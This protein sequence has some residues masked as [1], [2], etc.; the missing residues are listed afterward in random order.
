MQT[1]TNNVPVAPMA[2]KTGYQPRFERPV[3]RMKAT[4]S[5][6]DLCLF[7]EYGYETGDFT[8]ALLLD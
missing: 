4:E 7:E 8:D 5:I 6:N 1:T 2:A 3:Y